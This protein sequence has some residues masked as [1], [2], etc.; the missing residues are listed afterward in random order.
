MS[1]TQAQTILSKIRERGYWRVVIRPTSFEEKHIPEYSELFRIVERN[2]VRLAGWDYPHIDYKSQP[3]RGNDWVGARVPMGRRARGLAAVPERA[4]RS[5]FRHRGRVERRV[6]SPAPGPRLGLGPAHVLH[7]HG[8]Q[9][10]GNL[11]VRFT[12][13]PVTGWRGHDARRNRARESQRPPADPG[14]H[15]LSA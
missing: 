5:L 1:V 4:V 8:L 9:L 6:E 13:R 7:Q 15:S 2:A 14:D 12:A 3:E 10:L 11:R